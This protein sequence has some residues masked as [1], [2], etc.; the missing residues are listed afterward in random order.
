MQTSA[1]HTSWWRELCRA[2]RNAWYPGML[3]GWSQAAHSKDHGLHTP[4]SIPGQGQSG[5]SSPHHRSSQWA[6]ESGF[7]T[8]SQRPWSQLLSNKQ[9]HSHGQRDQV[10]WG[11]LL[12]PAQRSRGSLAA[13]ALLHRQPSTWHFSRTCPQ[14]SQLY[15]RALAAPPG[16]RSDVS[17]HLRHITAVVNVVPI[18]QA[19][20]LSTAYACVLV[21]LTASLPNS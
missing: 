7:G 17:I 8:V 21:T 19:F 10:T 14:N 11:G 20:P 18:P 2:G 12:C 1:Q 9:L 4:G 5:Q 15:P 16:Q 3:A 6:L 13:W